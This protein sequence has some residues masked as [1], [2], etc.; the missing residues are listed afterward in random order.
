MPGQCDWSVRCRVDP[1]HFQYCADHR[2]AITDCPSPLEKDF[3]RT[4]RSQNFAPVGQYCQYHKCPVQHCQEIRL[5]RPFKER[6]DKTRLGVDYEWDFLKHC[7]IHQCR[8]GIKGGGR[9]CNTPIEPT[10]LGT[11]YC[12]MHKNRGLD[13][14]SECT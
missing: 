3:W 7:E 4:F 5:E 8:Y 11:P 14:M 1:G 12:S 9:E 13:G 2:C 6:T 10:L